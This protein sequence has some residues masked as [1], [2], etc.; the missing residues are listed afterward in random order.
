[1]Q[2]SLS[3]LL[4]PTVESTSSSSCTIP[5]SISSRYSSE[6]PSSSSR[7]SESLDTQEY[8]SD[9]DKSSRYR[10]SRSKVAYACPMCQKTFRH[11]SNLQTHLPIHTGETPFKCTYPNC[12]K[13]FNVK[14]NLRRHSAIHA[15]G[16]TI[17]LIDA[18]PDLVDRALR[19]GPP[20]CPYCLK[21]FTQRSNLR[22]HIKRHTG[23]EPDVDSQTVERPSVCARTWY[24]TSEADI[25][26]ISRGP[27]SFPNLIFP[28]SWKEKRSRGI[29]Q[30][31]IL[32]LYQ[33]DLEV[34]LMLA[35]LLLL[36]V[37]QIRPCFEDKR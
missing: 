12:R 14:S 13:A 28:D 15:D 8:P 35:D 33:C 36:V 18:T 31:G 21:S 34:L 19:D 7:D 27:E 16:N 25:N 9:R 22:V 37:C 26:W 11:N 2:L 1:M 17:I 6:S 23:A 3:R 20:T 10:T 24:G 32:R 4:N 30:H 5:S 29:R